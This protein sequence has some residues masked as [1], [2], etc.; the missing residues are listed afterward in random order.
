MNALDRKG[1]PAL[2]VDWLLRQPGLELLPGKGFTETGTSCEQMRRVGIGFCVNAVHLKGGHASCLTVA[3]GPEGERSNAGTTVGPFLRM[4][5]E[6]KADTN[7][8]KHLC[9]KL[10]PKLKAVYWISVAQYLL[11]RNY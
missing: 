3:E 4:M 10:T 1:A 9:S 6:G 8:K 11:E 7:D 2:Q 5:A